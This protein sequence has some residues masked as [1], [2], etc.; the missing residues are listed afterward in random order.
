MIQRA[1]GVL[2]ARVAN[3]RAT[4]PPPPKPVGEM[5]LVEI[6]AYNKIPSMISR[7]RWWLF[8]WFVMVPVTIATGINAWIVESEHLSHGPGPY[9][10]YDHLTERKRAFPWRDGKKSLFHHPKY[11]PIPGEG[12]AHQQE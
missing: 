11:N 9:I 6:T 7:D 12:Y 3:A 5:N 2:R 10:P 4:A 1:L 8:T